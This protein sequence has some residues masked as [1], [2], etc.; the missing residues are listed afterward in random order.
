MLQFAWISRYVVSSHKTIIICVRPYVS[1][2]LFGWGR[3]YNF[4]VGGWRRDWFWKGAPTYITKDKVH[5][6]DV[7][8]NLSF[9]A[10]R[11]EFFLR[12]W[13]CLEHQLLMKEKI[14]PGDTV[15]D[16]G[17]NRGS[18]SSPASRL[19]RRHQPRHLL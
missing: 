5:G 18:F 3:V 4:F 2:E 8:L 9:Y 19:G 16:V 12:R 1:R 11:E 7:A 13:V 15:I 14:K 6:Y 17:A 10:D